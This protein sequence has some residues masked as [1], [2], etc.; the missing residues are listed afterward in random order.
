MFN[1][2]IGS[3]G[4]YTNC[5][6]RALGSNWMDFTQFNTVEE[7][8]EELK[9]QGFELDGIDEELFV[10]DYESDIKLS[11]CDYINPLRLFEQLQ[12]LG[13]LEDDNRYQLA[14][15]YCE[16]FSFEELMERVEKYGDC[17]DDDIYFYEDMTT[18]E[19]L[20]EMVEECYDLNF[21]KLGWLADYITIDYEQMARDTDGYHEVSN[22]VLEVR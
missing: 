7:I 16:A 1:V 14:C 6:E 2:V 20:Q 11:N 9:K 5:N 22:G 12:E 19:V 3:W 18:E 8:K 15:A 17:W 4:S 21:E 13:I 10:Q